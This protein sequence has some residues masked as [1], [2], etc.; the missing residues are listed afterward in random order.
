VFLKLCTSGECHFAECYSALQSFYQVKWQNAEFHFT[1]CYFDEIHS[2][3]SHSSE[4]HASVYHFAKHHSA[5]GH[6]VGCQTTER[7]SAKCYAPLCHHSVIM[8][9]VSICN[10][11][12]QS[13]IMFC[14]NVW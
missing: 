3:Q 13:V 1:K 7:D 2:A 10:V 4:C 5:V 9:S 11:I 14:A 12:P 8:P 6:S